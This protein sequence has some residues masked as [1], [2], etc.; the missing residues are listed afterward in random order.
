[1]STYFDQKV[2]NRYTDYPV[3]EVTELLPFLMTAIHGISR[4]RAKE[5][6]SQRMVYV[7][8]KI[9]T[10]FNTPL[11][12]GQLVQIGNR[13]H[14][15][16]L[17][18]RWVR[19]VY[20]DPFILVV[21]KANGI[22][23]NTQ[24][25]NKAQTVKDILDEY[26][27]RT[28]RSFAVHTVHCLDRQTSGLLLFAKRRDIQQTL[29]DNWQELITDR[30]YIA[31]CEGD[32]EQNSGTVSSW[33]TDDRMFIVHS[34]VTD[35]G[36]KRAITHYHTLKRGGGYSLVELKLDTG[37]KNQ[38]RVHM[39]DLHHSIAGDYKYGAQTDPLHRICLHAFRLAFRHPVTGELLKFET[40]FPPA[41][42]QLLQ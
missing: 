18:S 13:R 19:L 16:E 21:E 39:Q 33:L 11:R 5:L 10:Q 30:R 4:T 31:V 12:P 28:N 34:S 20:E 1:M 29:T 15:H 22:L 7:D 40:P 14:K 3:R 32:M 41:F 6:L 8:K 25:G 27:K 23:T 37:R 38:I 17:A 9:T 2:A 24:P 42:T 36:G 26:V 35:N